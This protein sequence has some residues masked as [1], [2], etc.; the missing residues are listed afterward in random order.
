MTS[1][2]GKFKYFERRFGVI[3]IKKG[4]IKKDDLMESLAI[5]VEE[6]LKYGDHR[7]VGEIMLEKD[8]MTASQIEE[9]VREIFR[10]RKLAP[11]D[12]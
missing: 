11:K 12:D 8:V 10:Y 3:A 2:T 6:E 9:V 1:K 5:Q 4:F 7:Q